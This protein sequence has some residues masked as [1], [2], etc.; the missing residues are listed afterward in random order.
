MC[1]LQLDRIDFYMYMMSEDEE[2]RSNSVYAMGVLVR[3]SRGALQT[4]YAKLVSDLYTLL[5]RESI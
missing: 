2:V 4:G 1:V 3:Q 5:K